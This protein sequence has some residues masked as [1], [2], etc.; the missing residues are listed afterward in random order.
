MLEKEDNIFKP[1]IRDIFNDT[2]GRIGVKKI[3][4]ILNQQGH[5][6]SL[7]RIS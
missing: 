3:K 4:Y 5:T 1:L 6:I 7:R 2:K